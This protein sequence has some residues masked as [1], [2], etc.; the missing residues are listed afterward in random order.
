MTT[1]QGRR[2]KASAFASQC[3]R[4]QAASELNCATPARLE[5]GLSAACL[6]LPELRQLRRLVLRVQPRRG[7][8]ARV[9]PLTSQCPHSPPV[10]LSRLLRH[11]GAP[12]LCDARRYALNC[13]KLE[14]LGWRQRTSFD[15]G[16]QR[17]MEWYEQDGGRSWEA[18][19]C[20]HALLPHSYIDGD[21]LTSGTRSLCA[22]EDDELDDAL[23]SA[24]V[25]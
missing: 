23:R 15:E 4:A 12:L 21:G 9:S 3:V 11:A 19:A 20:E 24:G 1:T 5:A 7:M 8:L 25:F 22:N 2:R 14:M 16:L 13:S 10:R 18:E 17:A 6:P